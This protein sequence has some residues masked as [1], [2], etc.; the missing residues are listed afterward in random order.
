[1]AD[2]VTR[3]ADPRPDATATPPDDPTRD[4]AGTAADGR[5][6]EATRTTDR[7]TAPPGLVTI[8][9]YEVRGEIARGNMGRVLAAHDLGF[10]REVAI[11]VV[12]R[13]EP[14]DPDQRAWAAGRFVRESRITGRLTHPNIPP[15]YQLGTLADGSPFLAMKLVRGRTLADLLKE[16]P[17]V[18]HDLPRFVAVFEQVAQAVGYA[19]SQGII[20][21]DLKPANVMVGAFGE[22]QVMDWGLARDT[23]AGA[24]ADGPAVRRVDATG[25]TVADDRTQAGAVMG[26]PAYMAPEQARGEDVDARAD[27][28]ALG[29]LLTSVLVGRAPFW[30]GDVA[31]TMRQAASGDTSEVLAALAGCTADAELLDLA[32][33]CLTPARDDRPADGTAVAA[34]VSAHRAGVEERLRT[35]E[36]ERAAAEAKAEEEANTRRE[37]E[38]KVVEQRRKRRAQLAAAVAAVLLVAGGGAA[39][40]WRANENAEKQAEAVRLEN[41]DIT[42]KALAEAAAVPLLDLAAEWLAEGDAYRA[43]PFV[44]A[45]EKGLQSAGVTTL[46]ERVAIYRTALAEQGELDKVDNFRWAS[47]G[48]NYPQP[49]R[50]AEEWSKA[51]KRL[52]IVP[53]VT[54]PADVAARISGSPILN[55]FLAALH[56][57]LVRAPSEPLRAILDEC[58]RDPFRSEVR[59]LSTA[60]DGPGLAGLAKRSEWENQPAWLV[61]AYAGFRLIPPEDQRRLLEQAA[62]QRPNNFA[63]LMQLGETYLALQRG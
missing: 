10:G 41:E 40:V 54:S 6:P 62:R 20:H 22:V 36:R 8:P 47:D 24:A 4:P 29:G 23:R 32:R 42:R 50:V 45:A 27:V 25:S 46:A 63:L 56:G 38:A 30:S 16:R 35:A 12:L 1:M 2:D 11:K 28:F 43:E 5:S 34:L 49:D 17:D 55:S 31:S 9:G 7:T 26:T 13:K 37:S 57:W 51:F 58:D 33:H 21:R 53:G 59:Q 18:S 60:R 19:H 15:A 14:D 48:T 3:P 52:G 44:D 39:A 61:A